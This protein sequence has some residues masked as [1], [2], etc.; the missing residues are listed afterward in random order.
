MNCCLS[1]AASIH[2]TEILKSRQMILHIYLK[3]ICSSQ[4]GV[5]YLR[6]RIEN[7]FH[8]PMVGL[9]NGPYIPRTTWWAYCSA[10]QLQ[11]G[12]A[13]THVEIM[14]KTPSPWHLQPPWGQ[15]DPEIQKTRPPPALSPKQRPGLL[16][17]RHTKVLL[18]RPRCKTNQSSWPCRLNAHTQLFHLNQ[19]FQFLCAASETNTHPSFHGFTYLKLFTQPTFV[20]IQPKFPLVRDKIQRYVSEGN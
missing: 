13:P 19:P 12:V 16:W 10:S 5:H 6:S 2:R 20:L 18:L 3:I 4:T 9:T 8:P 7:I 17:P 14:I 15:Q 1:E 11:P